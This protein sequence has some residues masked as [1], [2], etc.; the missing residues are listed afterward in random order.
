MPITEPR[1]TRPYGFCNWPQGPVV[2]MSG[3][4]IDIEIN[5]LALNEITSRSNFR[6]W[7]GFYRLGLWV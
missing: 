2:C 7:L 1:W 6:D 4:G 3:E 5:P